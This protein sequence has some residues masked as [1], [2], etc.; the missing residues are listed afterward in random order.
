MIRRIKKEE[1]FTIVELMITMVIFVLA[2]AASSQMF[3][4]MLTNF[5]QQSRIA[6]SNIE[7]LVGLELLRYDIEQAG[8]GLFWDI[9]GGAY[10]NEAA[11]PA[12]VYN[13]APNGVPRS[14]VLGDNLA[15]ATTAD[16]GLNNSDY[17]VVKSTNAA[18]NDAAQRF[19]YITKNPGQPNI[20]RGWG[21]LGNEQMAGADHVVILDLNQRRL[22][23]SGGFSAQLSN[24]NFSFNSGANPPT[25]A[26]E[27]TRD[28]DNTFLVY[29]IKTN[30]DGL[31][32]RMPFNR[33]DYY[34]RIPAAG[35]PQRCAPNTG[36]L[37]KATVNHSNG[38]LTEMPIM[39]CVAD[40]QVVFAIDNTPTDTNIN[41]D[42]FGAIPAGY[43]A[44]N[45]RDQVKEVRVYIVSHEGQADANYNFVG[46]ININDRD[47]GNFKALTVGT[48]ALE[49][50]PNYR[51]KVH[52][53]VLTPYNLR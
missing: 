45:I 16:P 21:T 40:M 6:E 30:A 35:M 9:S 39:D 22:I 8:F 24:N 5:K 23:N 38:A 34:V 14:F 12:N 51:W 28:V 52:R 19:T 26:F 10:A 44:Q 15:P 50:S 33:A 41:P 1:G 27:P 20:L 7:G 48:G 32:P 17:L 2:L 53:M 43:T 13:D 4:G 49:F 36:M 42:L 25:F 18:T 47:L 29:G 46:P 3:V 31:A 11:A 37:Y